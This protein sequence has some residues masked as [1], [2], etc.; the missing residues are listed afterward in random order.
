[1]G[2]IARNPSYQHQVTQLLLSA[3]DNYRWKP[4]IDGDV[5]RESQ[6]SVQ[7]RLPPPP[8]YAQAMQGAIV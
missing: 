6:D 8:T 5:D 1:M 7:L 2:V 3:L 4:F